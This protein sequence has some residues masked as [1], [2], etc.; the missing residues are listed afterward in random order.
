VSNRERAWERV[1]QAELAA[2]AALEAHD[3]VAW[4]LLAVATARRRMLTEA[5]ADE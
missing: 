2:R 4:Q 5:I 3:P 1:R